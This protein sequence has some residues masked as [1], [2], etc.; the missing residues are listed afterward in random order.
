M[1]ASHSLELWHAAI[2]GLVE[3]I[4]EYL[5][6]S[7]TGHLILTSSLL[8][9]DRDPGRKAALDH[10]EIV[11]QGGAILAV[12]GVYFP[13]MLQMLRGLIGRDKAGLRIF[14]NLC[15]AFVPSA[16]LAFLLSDAIKKY[17]FHPGPVLAALAVGGIYM[18]LVERWRRAR[19]PTDRPETDIADVSPLQAL[20][21]G[22]LQCFALIPG[23]SRA[24]MTITGGYLVGLP[25]RRAAEFSF[26]LGLPTLLAAT[27]YS[28]YKDFKESS[29]A[30]TPNLFDVLGPGAVALGLVIAALSA[31]IAVRW[32]VGFLGRSGLSPFGWYRLAL[33]AVLLIL[34][35]AGLVRI[36]PGSE[37]A[38]PAPITRPAAP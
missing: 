4:T 5:P 13:R 8:G 7:S 24:M 9:L 29:A 36:A 10:F 30:G 3:G 12:V 28:L 21:I 34:I 1:P 15:I 18:M 33:C 31:A 22:V 11:I 2:L 6:V 23:T 35:Q 17:L 20:L 25:P 26:L 37:P 32:L 16:A 19:P 14:L 27:V 38:P